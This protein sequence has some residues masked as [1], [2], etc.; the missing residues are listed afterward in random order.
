LGCHGRLRGQRCGGGKASGDDEPDWREEAH[1]GK[2]CCTE[3]SH[4]SE[5]V[6]RPAYR[7]SARRDIAYSGYACLCHDASRS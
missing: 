6:V 5:S 4:S 2:T 3:G 1:A 7:G